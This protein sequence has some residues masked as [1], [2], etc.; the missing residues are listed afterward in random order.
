MKNVQTLKKKFKK[1][2]KRKICSILTILKMKT[3]NLK[4]RNLKVKKSKML[5][6]SIRITNQSNRKIFECI[7]DSLTNS[8]KFKTKI[9]VSIVTNQII[10]LKFAQTKK[11]SFSLIK[12]LNN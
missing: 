11:K 12:F 6:K 10:K 8:K 4:L 3:K 2:K 7:V 9:I 5:T 1:F